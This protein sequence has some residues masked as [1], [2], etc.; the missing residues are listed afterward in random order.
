MLYSVTSKRVWLKLHRI[1]AS[2]PQMDTIMRHKVIIAR[3]PKELAV[4][5]V[6]MER[7]GG[8]EPHHPEGAIVVIEPK[9]QN[10]GVALMEPELCAMHVVYTTQN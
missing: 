1:T 3:N 6:L 9:P 7:N 4:S 2:D 10:G 5:L 8:G